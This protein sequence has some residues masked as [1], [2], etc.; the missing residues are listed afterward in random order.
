MQ[1]KVFQANIITPSGTPLGGWVNLT[2]EP[3]GKYWIHFH[4]HCSS[5]AGSFK[6]HLRAYLSAPGTPTFVFA[7]QG[8]VSGVRD[9]DLLIEN[10]THPLLGHY[11]SILQTQGN[12]QVHK[13]YN[14]NGALGFGQKVLEG[15]SHVPGKVA[16]AALSSV[17]AIQDVVAGLGPGA[18]F[19]VLG[20]G[21]FFIVGGML[22]IPA[23][24]LA[25]PSLVA[26]VGTGAVANSQIKS[27]GLRTEEVQLCRRV[28]GDTIPTDKIV[29]TNLHSFSKRAI[30]V[31]GMDGRI[32]LNLGD[33]FGTPITDRGTRGT[34]Y[35]GQTFIHELTHALQITRSI[36]S[37]TYLGDGILTQA[38]DTLLGKL[39]EPGPGGLAWA[40]Y[41]MEQQASI[42]ERWYAGQ[43]AT[44]GAFPPMDVAHPYYR[45]IQDDVLG[46]PSAPEALL[47]SVLSGETSP[48]VPSPVG[49]EILEQ[50]WDPVRDEVKTIA[51]FRSEDFFHKLA[52]ESWSKVRPDLI[53]EMTQFLSRDRAINGDFASNV[54]ITAANSGQTR[55]KET[56]GRQVLTL[57]IKDNTIRLNTRRKDN[58]VQNFSASF[59]IEVA[60]SLQVP[61]NVSDI[62]SPS[63]SSALKIIN[64]RLTSQE[65]VGGIDPFKNVSSFFNNREFWQQVET[66]F[67]RDKKIGNSVP[68][69]LLP[70]NRAL[71]GLRSRGYQ[72][73]QSTGSLVGYEDSS[74]ATF[75][76]YKTDYGVTTVGTGVTRGV[77]RWDKSLGKPQGRTIYRRLPALARA[78]FLQTP[79]TSPFRLSAEVQA[80]PRMGPL[81]VGVV[82][83]K[84]TR[85]LY[86]KIVEA[87]DTYEFHYEI[88]DLPNEFPLQ[89]FTVGLHPKV[90]WVGINPQPLPPKVALFTRE[91][92]DGTVR[93]RRLNRP[94]PIQI[95]PRSLQPP[96]LLMRRAPSPSCGIELVQD[97][98]AKPKRPPFGPGQLRPPL[99]PVVLKIRRDPEGQGAV[100][101]LDFRMTTIDQ[102]AGPKIR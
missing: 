7:H 19:G 28:F 66:V 81:G 77:I 62:V 101:R 59:D 52:N 39:Y 90:E 55:I 31:P 102:P 29:L 26:G 69:A 23:G 54:S 35:P 18:T 8:A 58:P 68:A 36:S 76:A 74:L 70:V 34:N 32:Y 57:L 61:S 89:L 78:Q 71:A 100:E 17:E 27:R 88:F 4:M 11:F 21:A 16:G 75:L 20:G 5:I 47:V 64:G 56:D 1:P 85:P 65:I 46:G 63:D 42:V 99:P 94:N 97:A 67:N 95:G 33:A 12:F 24:S 83:K 43:G 53:N 96:A 15:V 93:I 72:I 92:W 91:G 51:A 40:D 9:E 87:G 45:Y 30:T 84:F 25:I 86:G 14:W 38:S 41:N 6:Y 37:L 48:T 10:V 80:S 2:V 49:L 22:G 50:S 73:L 79:L 60:I 3:S 82:M 13:D 98:G 44:A